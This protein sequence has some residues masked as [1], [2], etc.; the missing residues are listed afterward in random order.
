MQIASSKGQESC[1]DV[2]AT[3]EGDGERIDIG[4]ECSHGTILTVIMSYTEALDLA[5]QLIKAVREE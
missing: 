4:L 3:V 2:N 1:T 5:I